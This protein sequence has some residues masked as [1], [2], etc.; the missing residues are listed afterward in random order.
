MHIDFMCVVSSVPLEPVLR[1][2]WITQIRK[3]Q[4]F[5]EI[6]IV[7]PVCVDHF[8]ANDIQQNGKRKT[9]KKGS[10]P[11]YFPELV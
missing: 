1:A 11:I 10:L 4:A 7:Y 2:K 5:D 9:L 3:H 6:P 8:D